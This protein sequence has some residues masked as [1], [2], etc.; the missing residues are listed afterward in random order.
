MAIPRLRQPGPAGRSFV[1]TPVVCPY[2]GCPGV[3]D[4]R[5]ER[6]QVGQLRPNRPG[7]AA[8]RGS[9]TSGRRTARNG[10]VRPSRRRRVVAHH[11]LEEG[12]RGRGQAHRRTGMAVPTFCTASA[13]RTRAVSTA[14]WSNSVHS[15]SV[16]VGLVLTLGQG[17]SP[18]V[19]HVECR[20]TRRPPAVVEPTPV[21]TCIFSS[22]SRL[23]GLSRIR[24]PTWVVSH[25]ATEYGGARSSAQQRGDQLFRRRLP[26]TTPPPRMSGSGQRL[27]WR[28]T[29]EPLR[30]SHPKACW[31]VS[32]RGVR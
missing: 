9:G 3:L 18:H 23:P 7:R 17:S 4:P 31:D 16:V 14:R 25:P 28:G 29:R 30:E 19:T 8:C 20:C 6:F 32:V 12:V 2:S 5:C 13:A 27:Q 15:R 10:R 1:S 22:H 26:N 11:L 21:R 24:L